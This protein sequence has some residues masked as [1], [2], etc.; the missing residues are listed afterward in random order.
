MKNKFDALFEWAIFGHLNYKTD[1]ELI[2]LKGHLI[3]EGILETAL[4]RVN[5]EGSENFSFHRK[6]E[7]LE[8]VD[9]EN[10]LKKNFII[11]S[12]KDLNKLR[13]K[14]AHD[15]FFDIKNGEFEL[16]SLN[17]LENLRGEKY[18]KY[19]FRTKIVH[20]FS[21]ISKNILELTQ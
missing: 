7:A 16:W 15:F 6:I 8:R 10:N 5:I 2:L 13:N 17:I 21:T 9:F 14:L 11:I 19:T 18:T 3:L 1:L 4:N 12:L 20:S